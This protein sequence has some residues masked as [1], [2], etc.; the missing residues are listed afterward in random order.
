[1]G[2]GRAAQDQM[3]V[4]EADVGVLQSLNCQAIVLR[5][6][7]VLLAGLGH[8]D[9]YPGIAHRSPDEVADVVGV[10]AFAENLDHFISSAVSV[11]QVGGVDL[12]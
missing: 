8:V 9:F 6:F 11:G 7:A 4:G 10:H 2:S 1:M 5:Y 3:D 12:V